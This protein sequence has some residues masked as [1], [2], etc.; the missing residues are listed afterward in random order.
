MYAYRMRQCVYNISTCILYLLY[1]YITY[2]KYICLSVI[3]WAHR[4]KYLSMLSVDVSVDPTPAGKHSDTHNGPAGFSRF[5][6]AAMFDLFKGTSD[7]NGLP[8]RFVIW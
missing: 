6:G 3:I 4:A 5:L 8:L 1:K 2:T 7:C